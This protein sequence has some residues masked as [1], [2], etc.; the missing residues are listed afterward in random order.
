MRVYLLR[1]GETDWNTVRRLQGSVDIPLNATGIRQAESWRPHFDGMNLDGIYSS[2]LDRALHTAALATGR[3]ACII[4]D[5]NERDFGIWEGRTWSD[6]ESTVS[7]FD[8]RWNDN[9]FYPPGGESR[10]DL[11]HRVHRALSQTVGEHDEDHEILIVAHG[12]SG[13][14]IMSSLLKHPIDARAT[15]PILTNASLTIMDVHDGEAS[16][17]GQVA[18]PFLMRGA[19]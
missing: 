19:L 17:A 6:L 8:E 11:Y 2:S 7:E 12:A 13:H 4:P 9:N 10:F 1:H 3:P 16:L 15:L 18:L 5:F 14:A